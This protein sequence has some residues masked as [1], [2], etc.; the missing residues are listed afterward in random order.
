M[1]RRRLPEFLRPAESDALL[2]AAT[3]RRDRLI[4]LIG[5][6]A[7]LRVSEITKLR[8]EHVDTVASTIFVSQGKGKKDRALWLNPDT[9]ELLR[10]WR[11]RREHQSELYFTTRDGGPINSRYLRAMM[12][13]YSERAGLNRHCSPHTLRHTFATD[14]LKETG[15]VETVRKALGHSSISVT[16]IYLH[17]VDSELEAA[18]KNFRSK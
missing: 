17:V 12:E 3:R 10:E 13:R 7:G 14:L 1:A 18:M 5:L 11:E 8:I 16:G 15:N 4:L 9:I 6:G 2:S